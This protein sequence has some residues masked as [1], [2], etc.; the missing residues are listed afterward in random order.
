MGKI[1][2]L[3]ELSANISEDYLQ[4]PCDMHATEA[5]RAAEILRVLPSLISGAPGTRGK[6][7]VSIF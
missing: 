2:F 7:E 3:R 5:G 1:C 6:A 4:T